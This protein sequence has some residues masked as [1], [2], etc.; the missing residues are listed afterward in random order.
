MRAI[1]P[2]LAALLI[3]PTA[4][5]DDAIPPEVLN[6]IKAATVFVKVRAGSIG[7]TGSGFL[8]Q[9]DG[10]TGLLVT[11]EHVIAPP[12]PKKNEKTGPAKVEVVFNSGRKTEVVYPAEVLAA[13]EE[14]DLAVLR[15]KNARDLPKPI[16]ISEKFELS[17]TMP[18]YMF[19][20]PFGEQLSITKGNPAI[21]IGKGSISS[22]RENDKGEIS[23]VQIDG[24]LN[25]GNSGGPVVDNKGRLVGVAVSVHRRGQNISNAIAPR[26]LD[27]LLNGGIGN[28][29]MR[30]LMI[31]NGV[32]EIEMRVTF[33]DP[34][35]RINDASVLVVAT[36][37]LKAPLRPDK[38]GK[39]APLPNAET[40]VLKIE[41]QLG[42]GRITL[43][44]E[45][46]SPVL[47]TFQP[48]FLKGDK[49]QVHGQPTS[50]FRVDFGSTVTKVDNPDPG[51]KV[52]PSTGGLTD[53][54]L[55]SAA[56]GTG[57]APA[58]L[59]WADDTKSFYHLD[60][61]GVVRRLSY[62]DLKEEAAFDTAK[63]CAWI[64]PS[65]QGLVVTVVET[66]EAWLLD[67]KTV[68]PIKNISIAGAKRVVSSVKSKFAYAVDTD[69][70]GRKLSVI[71]LG[72]GKIVKEYA[73]D[74]FKDKKDVNFNHAIVSHDGKQLFAIGMSDQL[75][76]FKLEGE[77]VECAEAGPRLLLGGRSEGI[78]LSA[79]GEHIAVPCGSGN[80]AVN[81]T[82]SGQWATHVFAIGDLQK[83]VTTIRSGLS[84]LAVGIDLKSQRVY[85]QNYQNNLIIFDDK[86]TKL[87][88]YKFD[89]RQTSETRQFL[90]H[91]DGRKFLA[92]SSSGL[93]KNESGKVWAVEVP[94]K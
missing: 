68:Q 64:S 5:A 67:P 33:L 35:N 21:T 73:V 69:P 85:A 92:L 16:N 20:F 37:T 27:E 50:P 38:E 1:I 26:E 3:H 43:K 32:A 7:G 60:G 76:R 72:Q 49:T 65:S 8:I 18:V 71:D 88:E 29:T 79:N 58:C 83:P 59:C 94:A 48:V 15:I 13:D 90:V 4:C 40:V 25:P 28:V 9:V 55:H 2:L 53:L 42:T 93:G 45:E 75:L 89:P 84:P 62:P 6:Q 74:A 82:A 31:Q 70:A 78:C 56:I 41:N 22:L 39:F 81:G 10:D 17:E 66:Q 87:K 11:N 51:P 34:L 19:G 12:N 86:G 46:R 57:R 23:L 24:A 80:A 77:Q 47:F 36:K 61:A 30:P 14:R 44:S 52:V 63:K 91:L 54:K